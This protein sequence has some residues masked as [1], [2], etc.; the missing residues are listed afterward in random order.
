M[1]EKT[2]RWRR[3]KMAHFSVQGKDK[4][5]GHRLQLM[6]ITSVLV[7]SQKSDIA[8]PPDATEGLTR[9]IIDLHF[10]WIRL[11]FLNSDCPILFS[12]LLKRSATSAHRPSR[13]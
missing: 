1:A 10:S 4:P 7:L 5:A 13:Q 9:R 12:P 6:K 11:L 3:E 2:Y 8:S